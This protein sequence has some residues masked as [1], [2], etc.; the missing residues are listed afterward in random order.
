[1]FSWR[2][3]ADVGSLECPVSPTFAGTLS[4]VADH[5]GLVL[6]EFDRTAL[7]VCFAS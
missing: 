7:T 2:C 6:A 3:A 4:R 5:V 1:V